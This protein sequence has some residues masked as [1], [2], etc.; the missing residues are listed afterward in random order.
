MR[1]ATASIPSGPH[2][3]DNSGYAVARPQCGTFL[4]AFP[5]GH[6]R[7]A[8]GRCIGNEPSTMAIHPSISHRRGHRRRSPDNGQTPTMEGNRKSNPAAQ[9]PTQPAPRV[10]KAAAPQGRPPALNRLRSHP[11]GPSGDNAH[12]R[13]NSQCTS[14]ASP[15]SSSPAPW[16]ISATNPANPASRPAYN[17]RRNTTAFLVPTD[18]ARSTRPSNTSPNRKSN[19]VAR[20]GNPTAT[21]QNSP[22]HPRAQAVTSRTPKKLPT[23]PNTTMPG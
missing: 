18:N 15:T 23:T 22:T 6:I 10:V 20:V 17:R 2:S 21:G 9:K 13:R 12:A 8:A 5:A 4:P 16:L 3:L 19:R 14:P 11:A 7:M 1:H